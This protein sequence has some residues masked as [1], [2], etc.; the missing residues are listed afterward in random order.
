MSAVVIA[1][2]ETPRV[3]HPEASRVTL[4]FLRDAAQLALHDAGLAVT[5]IDGLAVASFSLEPDRAID[6]AWRLGLSVRWLLQDTNGGAASINMLGHAIR[7]IEAGAASNILILAGDATSP[8]GVVKRAMNYN[9]ATRDHLAPLGHGGPNAMFSM[10]TTRQMRK[11][12]LSPT[13]YGHLV[14]AQRQWAAGNPLAAYRQPLTMDEYLNAPVVAAPL[15]RYDCVPI[16]SGASAMIVSAEPRRTAASVPVRVLALRTNFNYDHQEGDGLQTG[17][18]GL[19]A[20]LWSAA[21]VSP[22]EMDLAS[23]YDDYPAMA[24]AQLADLGIIVG[25]DIARFARERLASRQFPVNTGGG[26]L[27]GGQ[28]GNAGGLHGV[29]EVVRQL[30]HQGGNRQIAAARFGVVSG[31]GM[32]LYR[33]CAC[34]GAAVLQRVEDR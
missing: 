18:R 3:R 30:Q 4:T 5:D 33:Y 34:A 11:Y 6:L 19:A 26:M 24:F 25:D 10:L 9:S 23:V 29:V 13:D 12:G 28:P 2:G 21:G 31:Y 7:G 27:S 1:I 8:E 32:I 20:G 17:V 15:R 16:V 22:A 14:I